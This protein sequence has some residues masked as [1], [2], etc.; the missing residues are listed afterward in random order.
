MPNHPNNKKHITP[1][2]FYRFIDLYSINIA[3]LTELCSR[4]D[5]RIRLNENIRRNAKSAM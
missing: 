2:S 5:K 4:F 1:R 3:L